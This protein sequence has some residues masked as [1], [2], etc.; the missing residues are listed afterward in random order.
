MKLSKPKI[1][2]KKEQTFFLGYCLVVRL[3]KSLIIGGWGKKYGLLLYPT[4]SVVF[5]FPP[6]VYSVYIYTE[7]IR[8]QFR[9][10]SPWSACIFQ[11][12]EAACAVRFLS[13]DKSLYV[14]LHR[15]HWN[16][17][18]QNENLKC[19]ATKWRKTIGLHSSTSVADRIVAWAGDEDNDRIW[20]RIQEEGGKT[21]IH[22]G[23][24]EM[25]MRERESASVIGRK[26]V[27][28]YMTFERRSLQ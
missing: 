3:I 12:H 26:H 10:P 23:Q 6:T 2:T 18:H 22:V 15:I 28:L 9:D 19:P 27:L 7:Y 20:K 25:R 1:F 4:F 14:H 16:L 24:I 8:F 5:I 21:S 13:V 17:S 11:R